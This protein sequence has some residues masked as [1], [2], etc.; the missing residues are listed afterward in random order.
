MEG[1]VLDSEMNRPIQGAKVL[2]KSVSPNCANRTATTE[3]DGSFR[4][5]TA[6]DIH[7]GVWIA[8]PT[9]GTLIPATL[10]ED[11]DG[12]YRWLY[13]IKIEADGYETHH[14]GTGGAGFQQ[15][16]ITSYSPLLQDGIYRLRPR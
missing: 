13:A 2:V 1:K 16:G 10:F 14:W 11:G 15:L 8:P 6:W 12:I 4:I 9:S 3:A 5:A 7:F